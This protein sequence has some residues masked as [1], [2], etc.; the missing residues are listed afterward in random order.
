MLSAIDLAIF[1]KG[2]TTTH[3]QPK[4]TERPPRQPLLDPYPFLLDPCGRIPGTIGNLVSAFHVYG[5]LWFDCETE[6]IPQ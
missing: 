2:S 1:Q 6:I 5:P 3:V 4:K